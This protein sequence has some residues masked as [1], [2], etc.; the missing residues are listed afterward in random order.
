MELNP[1][2]ALEILK[3]TPGVLH[4]MLHGLPDAW[5]KVNEGP[6]TWSAYDVVGHLIHGEKTD[7]VPR[8]KIMLGNDNNKTFRPF[9]R[10][11]QF[12]DSEGKPLNFLLEE[13]NVL[14][15]QNIETLKTIGVNTS[16]Y[17]MEGIHPDFGKVTVKELLAAW[18][19]HDLGHIAQISRIMAK[20]LKIETGPWQEYLPVLNR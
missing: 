1:E 16:M 18:V 15:V 8:L 2:R 5:T 17:Q 20:Q 6:D 10:F 12:K 19:V 11:A 9:D 7:W 4:N 13:F 3:R 14:C